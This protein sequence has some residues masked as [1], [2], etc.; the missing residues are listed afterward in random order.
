[1]MGAPADSPAGT[2]AHD[3]RAVSA[4]LNVFN[5]FGGDFQAESVAQ[6]DDGA[7]DG[8]RARS[9]YRCS[10]SGSIELDSR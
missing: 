9:W 2:A 6:P 3:S 10:R 5:A 8:R 4:A 1:M 7:G